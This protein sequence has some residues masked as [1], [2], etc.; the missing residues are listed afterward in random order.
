MILF[1]SPLAASPLQ[2]PPIRIDVEAVNVLLTVTDR[3]GRFVTD[4]QED[5]FIVY[6]DRMPQE[7][8]HFSRQTD[9]PLQLGLLMDTSASVR[10]QLDFE[11]EA[12]IDF[13]HSVMRSHDRALLVEFDHGVTM[14]HDFTNRPNQIVE[15]IR[16]LRAGGGTALFDA[17]YT[18]ARDKMHFGDARKAIVLLSDGDD[19]SSRHSMEDA[20]KMAQT[21]D[22]TIFS[23]ATTRFGAS[24]R[25]GGEKT[26]EKLSEETGGRAFFPHSAGQLGEA[27]EL[28]NQELRSQYS[29]TYVPRNRERR[30]EYREIVVR[31]KDSKGYK[32]RHKKG[33]Y[34]TPLE[35]GPYSDRA[36]Q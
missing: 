5:D 27:F 30:G 23:I 17:V 8:T 29:L 21:S 36:S 18:V 31:I 33:Y 7:L 14:L 24:S 26:L 6:E 2:E 9:V 12:A 16:G 4:L 3:S 11:K 28:I 32:I 35:E 34:A 22:V 13:I 10:L 19:L 20:L 25:R 15:Q 1:L